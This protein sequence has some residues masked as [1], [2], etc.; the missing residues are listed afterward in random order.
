MIFA[1][2][3]FSSRSNFDPITK[4]REEAIRIS[5]LV[6]RSPLQSIVE[7]TLPLWILF[8]VANRS[9]IVPARRFSLYFESSGETTANRTE[10]R[11]SRVVEFVTRSRLRVDIDQFL[12]AFETPRAANFPR[13]ARS[14]FAN[15]LAPLAVVSLLTGSLGQQSAPRLHSPVRCCRLD[16]AHQ[17]ARPRR[18][19][20]TATATA[21]DAT[22]V[23]SL[24]RTRQPPAETQKAEVVRPRDASRETGD[25]RSAIRDARARSI[26][27]RGNGI[28]RRCVSLRRGER[29]PCVRR[30]EP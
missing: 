22:M 16:R 13:G 28:R 11:V 24:L 14:F 10:S 20:R 3:I 8:D 29:L 15:S 2:V 21:V 9:V 4:I 19:T 27:L 6:S 23:D 25:A 5:T 18:E 26:C 12:G 17:P 1:F 7:E 30:N